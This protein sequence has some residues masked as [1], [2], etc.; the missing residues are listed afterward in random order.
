MGEERERESVLE[1]GV[2]KGRQRREVGA[3]RGRVHG[4]SNREQQASTLCVAR[5][6]PARSFGSKLCR[7]GR[8]GGYRASTNLCY[9]VLLSELRVQSSIRLEEEKNR[10]RK[11]EREKGKKRVDNGAKRRRGVDMSVDDDG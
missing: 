10:R 3:G 6:E 4:G 11:R 8:G 7:E 9:P 2:C 1:T 5:G